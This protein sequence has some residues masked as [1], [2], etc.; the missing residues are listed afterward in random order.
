LDSLT[1]NEENRLK[2]KIEKMEIEKDKFE[3]LAAEIQEIKKS[4]RPHHSSN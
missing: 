3:A 1:I 4:I 2:R